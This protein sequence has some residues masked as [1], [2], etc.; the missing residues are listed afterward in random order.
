M[1][2][3]NASEVPAYN[4]MMCELF[5]A[6]KELGGSGTITEIDD[7]TIEI[8][9]LPVEVQEIMHGNSSKTEVEYRLAWT[10]SYMK[11]VGILENSSR[12][13]WSLTTK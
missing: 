3:K 5:Q 10:R 6:L 8:L 11:K 4:E 12:G 1:G 13:V 9:N 2:K 7:K